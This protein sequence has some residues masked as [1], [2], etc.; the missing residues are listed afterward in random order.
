M[1]YLSVSWECNKHLQSYPHILQ[2]IITL[3]HHL[4]LDVIWLPILD[5]A[6]GD[7]K[8]KFH[9]DAVIQIP[10]RRMIVLGFWDHFL[11]RARTLIVHHSITRSGHYALKI[12]RD[13]GS[14]NTI[15]F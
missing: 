5:Y 14:C 15:M 9:R 4:F 3:A 8:N 11:V 7:G 10:G 12:G 6:V 2:T 1:V 13:Y